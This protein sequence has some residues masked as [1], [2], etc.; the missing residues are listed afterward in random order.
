[1]LVVVD[2]DLAPALSDDLQ[3]HR[4]ERIALRQESPGI[5]RAAVSERIE[6]PVLAK[7]L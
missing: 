7:R 1:V 4:H 3:D 5:E 2:L 6:A